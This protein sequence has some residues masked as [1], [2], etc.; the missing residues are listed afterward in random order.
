MST[1][2]LLLLPPASSGLRHHLYVVISEMIVSYRHRFLVSLLPGGYVLQHYNRLG[3]VVLLQLLP[4]PSAM[5]SV[6]CQCQPDRYVHILH[7]FKVT[8]NYKI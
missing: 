1:F 8:V 5:E 3:D 7:G 2:L 6:S 4:E